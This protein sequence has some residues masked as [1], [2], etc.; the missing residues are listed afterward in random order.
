[1]NF[2][3]DKP[4]ISLVLPTYNVSRYIDRC[5]QSCIDQSCTNIEILVVDDCG[6]DDSV[7][8]AMKWAALDPRIRIISNA[9]NLGTY[10]ARRVGTE[11]SRADYVL[12]IDP[13]DTLHRDACLSIIHATEQTKP[14]IVLFEFATIPTPPWHQTPSV[15]PHPRLRR[16]HVLDAVMQTPHLPFGTP[17]KAYSKKVLAAAFSAL[18]I[19]TEE[20][21]TFA[22]DALLFFAALSVSSTFT[23]IDKRLYFY[24]RN[25][26]SITQQVDSNSTLKNI[27]QVETIIEH[28]K[29]VSQLAQIG[30]G[31][32]RQTSLYEYFRSRLSCEKHL[33]SRNLIDENGNSLYFSSVMH[34][35]K[36]QGH[37]K[38]LFRILIFFF[39]F[40]LKRP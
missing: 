28:M 11:N 21:L 5:L 35:L 24:H 40:G 14:D 7:S 2:M 6:T 12:Y 20:R 22:E 30:L 37:A 4:A 15:V 23:V 3:T 18:C 8:R 26:S 38:E 17:G 13:D 16:R 27:K 36:E 34:A 1:M 31:R 10:H 9:R 32:D 39:T 25:T 29:R 19:S 33:L